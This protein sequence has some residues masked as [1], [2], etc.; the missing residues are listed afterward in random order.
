M[1]TLN[2][3]L[4]RHPFGLGAGSGNSGYIFGLQAILA[5][6]SETIPIITFNTQ[7]FFAQCALRPLPQSVHRFRIDEDAWTIGPALYGIGSLLSCQESSL[8]V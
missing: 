5:A 4:R 8:L 6:W 2:Q 3:I 1:T 7:R